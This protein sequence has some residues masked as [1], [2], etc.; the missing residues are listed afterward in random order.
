MTVKFGA[1]LL[2]AGTSTRMGAENKLLLPYRNV[3]IIRYMVNTYRAATGHTVCV[4]TGHEAE[5]IEFALEGTDAITIFNAGYE[6]GQQSAV[7]L[8]LQAADDADALFIGLGDQP[9][10]TVKDLHFLMSAHHESGGTKI[11]VPIQ[12]EARGNPIIIPPNLREKVLKDPKGPGCKKFTR[13]RL[14]HV[15]HITTTRVSFF[16]DIDTPQA[17]AMLCESQQELTS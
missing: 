17:Y 7:K 10:I 15:H 14:E 13:T 4:I 9:L 1:I 3:P 16:A 2:A 5:Q 12:G 11:S 8:G 6:N